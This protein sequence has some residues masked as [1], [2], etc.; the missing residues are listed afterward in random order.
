[1]NYYQSFKQFIKLNEFAMIV[2]AIASCKKKFRNV[3]IE[4]YI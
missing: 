2:V 4:L 1:M 3:L